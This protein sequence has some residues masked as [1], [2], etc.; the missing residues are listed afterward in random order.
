MSAADRELLHLYRQSHDSSEC[1]ALNVA[2]VVHPWQ[3]DVA[4]TQGEREWPNGDHAPAGTPGPSLRPVAAD[5]TQQIVPHLIETSAV[6][7]ALRDYLLER[8]VA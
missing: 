5:K 4:A 6:L 2:G 3:K 7:D 1:Y 8:G